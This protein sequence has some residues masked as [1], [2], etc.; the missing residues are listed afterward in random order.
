MVEGTT[1]EL[2]IFDFRTQKLSVVPS[3]Q[4][5]L[6]GQWVAQDMLVAV[7]RDG[8][9]VLTFDFKTQKWSDLISAA[10]IN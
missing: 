7:P 2:Q 9:K 3:S 5:V 8:S 6:G 4:G 1:P 10:L